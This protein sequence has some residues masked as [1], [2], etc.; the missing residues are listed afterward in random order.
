MMVMPAAFSVV[1]AVE[2]LPRHDRREPERRLV[3]HDHLAAAAPA[4]GRAG[5]S[6]AG[7]RTSSW[8]VASCR[9]RR[10]GNMSNTV[11]DPTLHLAPVVEDVA[12]HPQVLAHRHV[13]EQAAVLRHEADA[14][15]QDLVGAQAVERLARRSSRVPRPRR[16]ETADHLEE[17]RLAGAVRPDDAIGPVR[18]DARATARSGCRA[19]CRSRR[20]RLSISRKAIS[21]PRDRLRGR[22]RSS[23]SPPA[24]PS[25]GPLP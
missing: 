9:S 12:A 3:E 16:Q 11:V 23:G 13:G 7:R 8:R 5:A 15:V 18:L 24:G 19:R 25:P 10:I 21:R 20:R 14:A 1:H 17:R 22:P 2:D 6:A 4:P